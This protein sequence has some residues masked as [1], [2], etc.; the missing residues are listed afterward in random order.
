MVDL[1][2]L[3]CI[4]FWPLL[5]IPRL[6]V[7]GHGHSHSHSHSHIR[8]ATWNGDVVHCLVPVYLG[9]CDSA[10]RISLE[11]RWDY[12]WAGLRSYKAITTAIWY[13]VVIIILSIYSPYNDPSNNICQFPLSNPNIHDIKFFINDCGMCCIHDRQVGQ[14]T[15]QQK[16]FAKRLRCGDQDPNWEKV[17]LAMITDVATYN[18]HK[19]QNI[20]HKLIG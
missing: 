1:Y 15:Q 11:L 12:C 18:W 17:H 4:Y 9:S 19:R 16:K 14:P 20:T 2:H 3:T 7:T 6:E 8:S 10:L 5:V 13:V